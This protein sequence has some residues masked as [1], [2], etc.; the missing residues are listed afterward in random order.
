MVVHGRGPQHKR[1]CFAPAVHERAHLDMNAALCPAPIIHDCVRLTTG[2]FHTYS[3]HDRKALA[4]KKLFQVSSLLAVADQNKQEE[5][6]YDEQT[7]AD[8]HS[9]DDDN[10]VAGR[11]IIDD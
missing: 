3:Y 1:G 8:G 11:D 10:Q 6:K 4:S 5:Q 9:H 7:T 2:I